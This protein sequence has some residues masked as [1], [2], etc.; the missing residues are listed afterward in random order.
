MWRF[1]VQEGPSAGLT[2]TFGHPDRFLIGRAIEAHLRLPENDLFVS[3]NHCL[4]E[5]YPPNLFLTDLNSKNGTFVNGR[6]RHHGDIHSGDRI[7]IGQTELAI[8]QVGGDAVEP[9]PGNGAQAVPEPPP[10]QPR[11]AI[12]A[13]P[14]QCC[15]CRADVPAGGEGEAQMDLS[16]CVNHMCAVCAA[17]SELWAKGGKIGDYRLLRQIGR[18]GMGVVYQA[19]HESTGSVVAL[20]TLHA[21]K[22]SDERALRLFQREIDVMTQL[23]HPN[24]VRLYKQSWSGEQHF[25]VSEWLD[26]GDVGE[27]VANGRRGPLP[28]AEALPI[29]RQALRGLQYAH[30]CG[31]VHRDVKPSNL[32]L[33]RSADGQTTLKVCDFGL[34]KSFAEAGASMM[35]RDGE[36]AGTVLYMAPEQIL[37]YRYVTPPA[38]VYSLG[39]T[40]YYVLTGRLPFDVASP[41]ERL[42]GEGRGKKQKDPILVVL[43][44]EPI[45]IRQRNEKIPEPIAAVIDRAVRKK[46]ME[47]FRTAMEMRQSLEQAARSCFPNSPS[48]GGDT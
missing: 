39:V 29:L 27:L 42:L 21:P 25:L 11:R 31:Y 41:L 47:R 20:K 34:A 33:G 48:Y 10:P 46:E 22:S 9:P 3:R 17:T 24:V 2:F 15:V 36:A 18:G 1:Q 26:G 7:R 4:I 14:R 19:W 38:D 32:L 35:T 16:E 30:E 5:I 43:E 13:P 37:N 44:D 45:P 28:P 23:R 6:K 40:S 12:A 8:E